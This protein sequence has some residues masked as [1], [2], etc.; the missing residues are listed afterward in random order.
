VLRNGLRRITGSKSE[1]SALDWL[2]GNPTTK[3]GVAL[4]E[5]PEEFDK[6]WMLLCWINLN[7]RRNLR[8]GER[9]S[10]LVLWLA[11]VVVRGKPKYI[12]ALTF[13]ASSCGLSG[14]SVTAVAFRPTR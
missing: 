3:P 6:E 10:Q 7:F 12:R 9:L 8:R 2:L 14:L 13:G 11:L 4:D 1:P 5:V